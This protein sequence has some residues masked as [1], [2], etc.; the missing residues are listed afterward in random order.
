MEFDLWRT[1]PLI[2][3]TPFQYHQSSTGRMNLTD[4][5]FPT[6]EALW[7]TIVVVVFNKL[8]VDHYDAEY[9]DDGETPI[10]KKKN[11]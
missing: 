9:P 1:W 3:D 4:V 2:L 10:F 6:W 11:F 8:I 7:S 5:F